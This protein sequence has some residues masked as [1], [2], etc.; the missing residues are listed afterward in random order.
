MRIRF[1]TVAM[2]INIFWT[3]H[4]KVFGFFVLTMQCC[5]LTTSAND[6]T[7]TAPSVVRDPANWNVE[8]G[9]TRGQL[10]DVRAESI[11]I[12]QNLPAQFKNPLRLNLSKALKREIQVLLS[13]HSTNLILIRFKICKLATQY[14]S[15]SDEL[16][17][18]STRSNC[19][20]I[21]GPVAECLRA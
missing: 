20:L 7:L 19:G 5:M 14:P 2:D 1:C 4:V 9:S 15:D 17:A 10:V 3:F 8:Y 21:G 16:M 6:P 12:V 11:T 13:F 18:S